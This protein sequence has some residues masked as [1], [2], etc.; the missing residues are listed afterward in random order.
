MALRPPTRLRLMG[1]R[2][3]DLLRA[4]RGLRCSGVPL[5]SF[6]GLGYRRGGGGDD[7]GLFY[8]V[9]ELARVL[10]LGVATAVD[11]T[12]IGIV[13]MGS[14]VGLYGFMRSA[15]TT[16]GRRVGI[17]AF[18]LLTVLELVGGDVYVMNAA[19]AIAGV[20]WILYFASRRRV[21][22]SVLITFVLLGIVSQAANFIRAYAGIGLA[23]F[24]V[25]AV[26]GFYEL[27]LAG[28]GMVLAA[29]LLAAVGAQMFVN[30]LYRQRSAFLGQQGDVLFEA[31]QIHPF[32]HSVYIGLGY[33]KNA[34]VPAYS[35]AVAATR[36]RLVRPNAP[37]LSMEYEDVLKQA[38]L[39]LAKR[40][41]TLILEN[42]MVKLAVVLGFCIGAANVGLYAAIVA[43]KPFWLETAFWVSMAFNSLFGI[44]VVP[45]PR[46]LLGL[47]AFAT[48]Y[49]VYSLEYAAQQPQL[50]G[51]L[52]WIER[53]ACGWSRRQPFPQS[54]T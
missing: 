10:H 9:P 44:L 43:R 22:G 49:G 19:P 24:A 1:S 35:D 36:V 31:K 6:D 16:L 20:P 26:A 45:S 47:I 21:T 29:F 46:Y 42:V 18:L 38:T 39:E 48:L 15:R 8:V 13:L 37:Y 17:I 5:V 34:E 11:I 14:G 28:K 41:P 23:L 3:V 52:A 50:H 40:R 25:L 12:L 32:W 7:P 33:V 53:L 2:Y 27:R 54:G 30:G 51:G 4:A